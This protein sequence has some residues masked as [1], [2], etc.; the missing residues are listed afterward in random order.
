MSKKNQNNSQGNVKPQASL[1]SRIFEALT[2][3]E[4]SQLLDELF[5]T[6]IDCFSSTPTG[7]QS[8]F[9]SN[10]YSTSNN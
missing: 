2:K 7:Y 1:G 3:T 4:I 9:N 6:A 5:V 8:N 10:Y